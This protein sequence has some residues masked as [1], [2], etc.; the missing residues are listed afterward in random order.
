M[1]HP[2][3]LLTLAAVTERSLPGFKSNTIF[4]FLPNT[5]SLV[6]FTYITLAR[7]YGHVQRME[8]RGLPKEVTKW[9]PP[10]RRKRG[11]PIL[12]FLLGISPASELYMSTF[13]NTLSVPSS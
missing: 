7:S 5:I 12:Y 1:P 10:G 4:N 3:V 9:G 6:N 8:E 2:I 13:R 11:R